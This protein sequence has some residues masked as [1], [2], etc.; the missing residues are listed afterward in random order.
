MRGEPAPPAYPIRRPV[1]AEATPATA[2]SPSPRG[3]WRQWWAPLLQLLVLAAVVVAG[4]AKI[5]AQ[6]VVV[7]ADLA[8]D[9]GRGARVVVVRPAPR[10]A[11]PVRVDVARLGIHSSLVDLRKNP[12]GSVQVP[13][14]YGIAGW[15]VGSAHPGDA[16][17][18]VL[19]GHVDSKHGPGIFYAVSRLHPG[20]Q[21]VVTRADR[22]RAV[23][24]VQQV[25]RYAKRAFPTASVYR[26]DR[27]ASLRLVTCGGVFDGRTGHYLDNTVVFAEPLVVAAQSASN[28][29]RQHEV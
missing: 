2:C 27:R 23:F 8:A 17:P 20:D 6:N 26:G 25:Q 1:A 28:R 9:H 11:A 18:T 12:D 4:A 13:V 7:A 19:I 16:G 22:S 29:P 5:D 24:V 10:H 14:D 21:I 15:Y 3:W